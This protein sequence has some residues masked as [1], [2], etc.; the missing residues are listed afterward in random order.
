MVHFYLLFKIF[1]F[2]CLTLII[3]HHR[4]QKERSQRET[5]IEPRVKFN[6]NKFM[7]FFLAFFSAYRATQSLLPDGTHAALVPDMA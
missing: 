1:I 7:Q 2:P 6:P 5:K 4:T 3:S